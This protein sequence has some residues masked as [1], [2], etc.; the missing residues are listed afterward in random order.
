MRPHRCTA[1]STMRA[2]PSSAVRS[3]ASV[4]SRSGSIRLRCG[5]DEFGEPGFVASG[6]EHRHPCLGELDRGA[7]ADAA[8]GAR[9]DRYLHVT[10]STFVVVRAPLGSDASSTFP[11]SFFGSASQIDHLLGHLELRDAVPSRNSRSAATSG[12]GRRA[13]T[14]TA[15]ARSPVRGVGQPDHRHLGDA[16][17]ADEDVLDLLGRDVL[18][19]ADD[20]VLGPAG[21]HQASPSQRPRSPVRK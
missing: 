15:H 6:A 3:T 13:A 10:P 12:P 11:A 21:D 4:A 16:G 8:A 5:L 1:A 7:E 2:G 17:M 14:I 18:A 20:D 9:D 19:V